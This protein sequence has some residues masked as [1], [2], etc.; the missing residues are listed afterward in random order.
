MRRET[1]LSEADSLYKSV[2]RPVVIRKGTPRTVPLSQ[3]PR[4]KGS[5]QSASALAAYDA[6]TKS[7]LAANGWR[8]IKGFKGRA[9]LVEINAERVERIVV[10]D[11]T[12]T[13]AY[14][15]VKSGRLVFS[16]GCTLRAGYSEEPEVETVE[17]PNPATVQLFIG[18]EGYVLKF[19]GVEVKGEVRPQPQISFGLL[20]AH[21]DGLPIQLGNPG[22][23]IK[24]EMVGQPT[25]VIGT[26]FG[27][28][29]KSSGKAQRGA[30][31]WPDSL[32]ENIFWRAAWEFAPV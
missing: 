4:S 20:N 17:R 24:K 18:Q 2:P 25:R 16:G 26:V 23:P 13:K 1:L 3:D 5:G 31:T 21:I 12:T 29:F 14:F 11:F 6:K 22:D 28:P 15:D 7:W 32:N 9:T 10:V 30:V 27:F 19:Q 8:A